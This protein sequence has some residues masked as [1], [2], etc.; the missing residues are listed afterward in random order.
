MLDVSN[1]RRFRRLH[2]FGY[3]SKSPKSKSPKLKSPKLKSPKLKSPRPKSPWSKS[4]I[5]IK[6][7]VERENNRRPN[8]TERVLKH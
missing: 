3:M 8:K 5:R 6:E 4:K 1:C 2:Q 7:Y